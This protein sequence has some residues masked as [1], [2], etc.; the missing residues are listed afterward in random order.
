MMET[1]SGKGNGTEI[2]FQPDPQIFP[3]PRLDAER[4]AARMTETS[5]LHKG[6]QLT[7]TDETS[8]KEQEWKQA[9]GLPDYF[10]AV[11]GDRKLTLAPEAA[12][13]LSRDQLNGDGR[14]EMVLGW[15]EAP[16]E[17]FRSYVNGIP[18]GSGGSHE[19]G[20]R[21]GL[22][23]A[24]RNYLETHSL[25][26]R[27]VTIAAE[28]IR[29]GVLA[30]LSVFLEN[31][32]FQGQT[33]DRLNN[34]EVRAPVDTAVRIELERW[35]NQS[36]T[37]AE[38][39]ANRV[40]LAAR[41]REASRAASAAVSRKSE[42]RTRSVL[43]GKLSDCASRNA[44]ETEIFIVEGDSAGGSAKQGR[45]RMR[46]AVLPLRGKILNAAQA[47]RAKVADNAELRDIALALGCGTGDDCDPEKLR[48]R[49][50]VLLADA[51]AD[52]HHITTLL[53]AYFVKFMWKL[54]E[55][56]RVFVAQPPLYRVDLG[57]KSHWARDEADKE[58]ILRRSS[59]GKS[60]T[61]TRFK[62]LG[63]MQPKV[64]WDTTLNPE[65]RSLLRVEIPDRPAADNFIVNLMG[66]DPAER[67]LL[68]RDGAP[69]PAALDL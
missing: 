15:T 59:G 25:I 51:D 28:D 40:V 63:E 53:L 41:A 68:I 18:T 10:D 12:F 64:L 67:R 49:R 31:P 58:A 6:L 48:Y 30:I 57:G 43:P 52:G 29:E 3:E 44:D 38:R 34:P 17:E 32:Q 47:T 36:P 66:K 33:K 45:D 5:Y 61:I 69:D 23:K 50:V 2:T 9:R 4:I 8:G 65:T 37:A 26:P 11:I 7:F 14:L 20:L 16:R 62:G 56:G 1:G 60:P 22:A 42:T 24:V 27:G 54:L 13:A 21:D 39:I 19:T 35:L 46:Q 55:A